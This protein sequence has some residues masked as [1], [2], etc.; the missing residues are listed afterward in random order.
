MEEEKT[1]GVRSER[2]LARFAA[3]STGTSLPMNLSWSTVRV[4]TREFR[5]QFRA[6][7]T[8]SFSTKR[9]TR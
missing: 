6:R 4:P 3:I 8:G 5:A 2:L 9:W 7:F 1:K